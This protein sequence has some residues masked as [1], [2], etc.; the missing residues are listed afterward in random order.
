[1]EVDGCSVAKQMNRLMRPINEKLIFLVAGCMKHLA[2]EVFQK[3]QETIQED[4]LSIKAT[5]VIVKPLSRGVEASNVKRLVDPSLLGPFLDKVRDRVEHYSVEQGAA[6][7]EILREEFLVKLEAGIS[8]ELQS[9]GAGDGSKT[10]LP[11]DL[12]ERAARA[13]EDHLKENIQDH[14][15]FAVEERIFEHLA[16]EFIRSGLGTNVGRSTP[17]PDEVEQLD[18]PTRD[19][20]DILIQIMDKVL[21]RLKRRLVQMIADDFRKYWVIKDFR[22]HKKG[23]TEN[24]LTR[25]WHGDIDE[26]LSECRVLVASNLG[27]SIMQTVCAALKGNTNRSRDREIEGGQVELAA[28]VRKSLLDVLLDEIVRAV[29]KSLYRNISSPRD[30]GTALMQVEVLEVIKECFP[31]NFDKDQWARE[32]EGCPEELFHQYTEVVQNILA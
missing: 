16:Q 26:V 8:A 4:L 21:L 25:E 24:S 14:L 27:I 11:D 6:L 23:N 17:S 9:E 13:L 20:R 28:K 15:F 31:L 30:D 22:L 5:I 12:R 7:L 2:Q 1:M 29:E 32:G 18:K 19:V 3:V 10:E